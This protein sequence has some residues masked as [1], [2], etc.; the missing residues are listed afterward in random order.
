MVCLNKIIN[1]KIISNKK[2]LLEKF[3]N[4]E[5]ESK[6]IN[7]ELDHDQTNYPKTLG[8]CWNNN[9]DYFSVI[10]NIP[11]RPFTKRGILATVNSI[12]DPM[13]FVGPVVLEGRLIQRAIMPPK[14]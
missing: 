14:T 3:P 5:V 9:E 13:G 1:N 7:K 8:I 6:T 12:Y 4:T 2:E 10:I 11:D